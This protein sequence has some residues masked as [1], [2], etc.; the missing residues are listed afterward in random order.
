VVPE[1]KV[2]FH[3]PLILGLGLGLGLGLER[4][5]ICKVLLILKE[6]WRIDRDRRASCIFRA[7]LIMSFFFL[8][9]LFLSFLDGVSLI[10]DLFVG[11]G[12]TGMRIYFACYRRVHTMSVVGG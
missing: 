6:E 12:R 7:L 5:M 3:V 4:D 2:D 8:S 10:R 11:E 1:R 9:F